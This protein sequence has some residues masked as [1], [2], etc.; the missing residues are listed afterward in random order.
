MG[1]D[2]PSS[3][4]PCRAAG[5]REGVGRRVTGS[6]GVASSPRPPAAPAASLPWEVLAAIDVAS[7]PVCVSLCVPG[8]AMA[9]AALPRDGSG[10]AGGMG[11]PWP[12]PA[13]PQVGCSG[14]AG[15]AVPAGPLQTLCTQRAGEVAAVPPRLACTAR[16]PGRE[17]RAPPA[18]P[19]ASLCCPHHPS[20]LS[21][22]PQAVTLPWGWRGQR[23]R[24]CRGWLQRGRAC[25]QQ[26]P[27]AP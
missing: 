23:D 5:D 16:E 10:P 3:T 24:P 15:S 4:G 9:A 19:P 25:G 11:S 21:P 26:P 7:V 6:R 12:V 17:L 1:G 22:L 13:V 2:L 20:S 27:V 18:G 8:T 14:R